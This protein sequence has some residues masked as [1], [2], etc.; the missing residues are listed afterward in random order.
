MRHW[1]AALVI[2]TVMFGSVD[3]AAAACAQRDIA[4]NWDLYFTLDDGT[5]LPVWLSCSLQILASGSVRSGPRCLSGRPD[6]TFPIVGGRLTVDQS[7][8]VSGALNLQTGGRTFPLRVQRATMAPGK[9]VFLGVG[10]DPP[11]GQITVDAV[12]R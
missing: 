8:I 2:A 12:R 3:P 1:K 9:D 10:I 11:A 4:G 5:G 6:R 7:C